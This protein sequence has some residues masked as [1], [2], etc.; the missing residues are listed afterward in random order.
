[1]TASWHDGT[2]ATALTDLD[3]QA[4]RLGTQGLKV[5]R[6]KVECTLVTTG[7]PKH[8]HAARKMPGCYFEQHF[9]IR[10]DEGDPNE[11]LRKVCKAHGA[12]MARILTPQG[13]EI[14]LRYV[15]IRHHRRGMSE[16]SQLTKAFLAALRKID[17]KPVKIHS[18]FNVHDSNPELD[19]GWA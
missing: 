12:E 18:E 8:D 17:R 7:V 6:T 5:V 3:L 2:L 19:R 15:T 11:G 16:V 9:K 13:H 10:F 4:Q 14:G 1:M